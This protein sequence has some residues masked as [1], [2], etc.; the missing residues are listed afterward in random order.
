MLFRSVTVTDPSGNSRT[1]TA[2]TL[3][4][5]TDTV[6]PSVTILRPSAA[7]NRSS[8]NPLVLKASDSRSGVAKVRVKV[9]QRRSTGW[10]HFTGT[11]WVKG[12]TATWIPAARV[13][14]TGARW[15]IAV[16]A[17]TRGRLVVEARSVD[18]AGNRSRT[19]TAS[20]TLSR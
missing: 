13:S 4:V 8:W 6:K 9:T 18:A 1:V 19:S 12:A 3:T 7:S 16:T 20:V 14:G 11:S 2:A 15:S 17:L 5:R 10:Y